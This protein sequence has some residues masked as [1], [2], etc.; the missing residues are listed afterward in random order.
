MKT[1]TN[2]FY[3]TRNLFVEYTGYTGPLSYEEW[4]AVPDDH[5]AAVLFC[6]FFDVITLAWYKA[7]S[8]YSEEADGVAEVLQYLQ[9]AVDGG[10][11]KNPAI[12]IKGNP[13]RFTPNYIYRISYN[14]LYCLCR[15]PNQHKRRYENECSNIVM[16]GE[17]ELDLFDTVVDI[18]GDIELSDDARREK[19]WDIIESVGDDAVTVVCKLL[20]EDLDWRK[21]R[22][23]KF[24]QTKSVNPKNAVE[25]ITVETPVASF[26]SVSK[27]MR[28]AVTAEREQEIIRI[29]QE[30][31][32]DFIDLMNP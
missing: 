30:R 29:L 27:K 6:Q 32:G 2:E 25:I 26:K 1:C 16:C 24:V 22:D 13:K 3:N 11:K 21:S 10:K 12:M 19:F 17:D 4:L 7:A 20:G 18:N 31:L 23:K 9:K 5:K 8:V 28:E 15:D 14:C